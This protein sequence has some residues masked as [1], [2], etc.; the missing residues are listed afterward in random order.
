[1]SAN[2]QVVMSTPKMPNAINSEA[3][4]QQLLNRDA[5]AGFVYAVKTTGVF[6]RLSC[7]SRLPLR[8]NV[9]F[10]ATTN[11]AEAAGFRRCKRCKPLSG[12]PADQTREALARVRTYLERNEDRRVR[13]GHLGRI[14]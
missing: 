5:Q 11:E 4:W 1:M 7:K 3:A 9:R 12:G 2:P 13:L 14:A 6:C 8:Q 10:F